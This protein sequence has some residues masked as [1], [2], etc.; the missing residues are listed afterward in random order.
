MAVNEP[1]RDLVSHFAADQEDE[2]MGLSHEYP[3]NPYG[4]IGSGAQFV[5]APY[6]R[7][8]ERN[9]NC[10]AVYPVQIAVY[11]PYKGEIDMVSACDLAES[12]IRTVENAFN[13]YNDASSAATPFIF[14]SW[15][16]NS[17]A[18]A[19]PMG[20]IEKDIKVTG[21][22]LAKAVVNVRLINVHLK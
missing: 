15:Q 6:G 11:I 5:L 16:A 13:A 20:L 2:G 19:P 17:L 7:E 12:T 4:L 22:Y 9:S 8:R 10:Y 1:I 18:I 14:G 3:V 21:G